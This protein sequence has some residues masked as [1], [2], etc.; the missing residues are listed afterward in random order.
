MKKKIVWII[1]LIF[2]LIIIFFSFF[3]NLKRDETIK[4]TNQT[5]ENLTYNS[6][7][8]KDVNYSSKDARGN[9]YIIKA[10]S[11]E[12]DFSNNNIIFLTEVNALIK[13]NNSNN[14]EIYSNYGKYNTL[15]HDTIFTKN[16]KVNYLENKITGEY[17][18]FS[19]QRNSMIISKDVVYKNLKNILKAD[20]I[21]VNIKTKDTKIFMYEKNKKVNVKNLN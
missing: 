2:F 21:E 9:E 10:S 11:G 14:V 13:L 6:N 20:V 12:I 17:L 8:L 5:E 4:T 7:I 18:D 3:K 19:I 15:N 16:V 1:V